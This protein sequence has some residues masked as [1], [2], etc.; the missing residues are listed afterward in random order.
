MREIV[1]R[2][3]IGRL[4]PVYWKRFELINEMTG[5][6][7]ASLKTLEETLTSSAKRSGL[8][9]VTLGKISKA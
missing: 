6:T 1:N 4:Q 8:L 2:K 9:G 3:F 7:P 5:F